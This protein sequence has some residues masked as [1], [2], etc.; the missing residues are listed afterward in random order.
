MRKFIYQFILFLSVLLTILALSLF[1]IPNKRLKNSSL[2]SDIDKNNRLDL[3]HSPKIIFVGGSNIAFGLNSQQIEDSLHL[4]V[5]NMGLHA[6][7]GMCFMLNEIRNHVK[8]GDIVVFAPEYHQF[9]GNLFEGEKVLVALL[10]DINP[11]DIKD[12]TIKQFLHLFPSIVE[13]SASKIFRM[14]IDMA[15][16]GDGYGKFFKRN[17][18]N[19]YGD[20]AMHWNFPY[21]NLPSA[22][23]PPKNTT[24]N[25]DAFEFIKNFKKDMD[26]KGVAFYIIPPAFQ[27]SS[28]V[29]YHAIIMTIQKKLKDQST[30]FEIQPE[31]CSYPDNMMFNTIYHLNKTGVDQRTATIIRFLKNK[32]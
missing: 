8:Q 21:H 30:P 4:P 32:I 31:E 19:K 1:L 25:A 15:D 7:L 11:K 28:F 26:K 13:Y 6:G 14:N 29:N 27:R 16:D 24:I 2:Y 5:V 9:L 18:F 3:L 12:I 20:E 10:F 22:D 23:S 17:S